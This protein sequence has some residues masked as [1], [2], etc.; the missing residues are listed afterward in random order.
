MKKGVKIWGENGVMSIYKEMKQFHDRNV[1]NP[2]LPS[3][4]TDT[5]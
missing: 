1:V 5:I 4:I 3:E 2:L